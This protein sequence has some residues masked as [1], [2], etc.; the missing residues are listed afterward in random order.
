MRRWARPSATPS[1]SRGGDLRQTGP[2]LAMLFLNAALLAGLAGVGIP[3]IIHLLNRRSARVVDWGAMRFLLD[4]LLTRKR[5]I[6]LEEAL[7]MAARCLLVG[8]LALAVARPFAPPGS[9]VPWLAVLPL[10]LGGIAMAAVTTVLWTERHLRLRLLGVT[11]LLFLLCGAAVGLERWLNLR[12]FGTPGG[13]DIALV[14]D[15]SAS[16]GLSPAGASNFQTAVQEAEEIIA[17][18]GSGSAFAVVLAGEVPVPLTPQPALNRTELLEKLKAAAPAPGGA[19]LFDAVSLAAMTLAEGGNP[20]KEIIVITDGQRRG[21][22]VDE[23]ARWE[24]LEQGLRQ[25]PGRPSLLLRRLPLPAALRNLAVTSVAFSRKVIGIDRPVGIEVTLSNTGTEAVTP[26][27]LVLEVPGATLEETPGTLAPG[28]SVPV[29]FSHQFAAPGALAVTARLR[30]E[31][32][33][34]ADNEVAVVAEV[35]EKISVLVIEGSVGGSFLERSGTLAALALS[36]E[37][38]ARSLQNAGE[39]DAEGRPPLIVPEVMPLSRT[40]ALPSF[41][42]H[43]VVVLADVPALAPSVARLLGAFVEAGGGVL[44]AP[45]ASAQP[46]FYNEWR[47]PGSRRLV[48]LPLERLHLL[49]SPVGP[50]PGTFSHP[51]L[52]LVADPRQSDLPALN[53]S[54]HWTLAEPAGEAAAVGGRLSHGHPLFAAQQVGRGAVALLAVPLDPSSSNLPTRQAFVPLMHEIVH[55]LAAAGRATLNLRPA[56]SV[57][58]PLFAG[59][60]ATG[61]Q[62]EYFD[63]AD[64]RRPRLRRVD[65]QIDFQWGDSAPA[66]VLPSDN[67]RVRWSG[68]LVPQFTEDYMLMAEADDSME[69]RIGEESVLGP[70]RR[71]DSVPLVAGR[72]VPITVTFTEV[73][74]SARARLFWQSQSQRREIIPTEALLPHPQADTPTAEVEAGALPVVFP[75]GE[76]GEARLVYTAAGPVARVDTPARPGIYRLEVPAERRT[77]FAPLPADDGT[78]PFAVLGDPREGDLTP[79]SEDDLKLIGATLPVL[80]ME[81]AGQV[82]DVLAGRQTGEELWKYLALGALV[83]ALAEIALTRWIALQRQS[84]QEQT[85]DFAGRHAPRAEFQQAVRELEQ[86]R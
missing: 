37:S 47:T 4:S 13:R 38:L 62:G 34:E 86:V 67:F 8:L 2:F 3:I 60:A 82:L 77:E 78:L 27:G 76:R 46:G 43:D 35:R 55:H 17:E 6:Q 10:G 51:A 69:V 48:P 11:L 44:V 49:E 75:D 1:T 59:R 28:A 72:P 83:L 30:V 50:A 19:A 79:L 33:L 23:P 58:V 29:M 54:R 18:A 56:Y 81:S 52:R 74:G 71:R 68:W 57:D 20:Q 66:P 5:R 39:A 63:A 61:L 53:V 70:R 32:D 64:P 15:A 26:E 42:E 25:L 12:R 31:D 84:G 14:I 24:A 22:E 45:G 80:P 65:P 7:L 41:G 73:A 21:W 16:M 85:I 9:Q 36:P 40:A